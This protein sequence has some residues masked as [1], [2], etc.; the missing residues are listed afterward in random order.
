MLE[1]MCKETGRFQ[2]E[3]EFQEHLNSL[4]IS[5]EDGSQ[6]C[7]VERRGR[8]V[9]GKWIYL[10]YPCAAVCSG[11]TILQVRAATSAQCC[12]NTL[13]PSS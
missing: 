5:L 2:A 10:C 11:E 12:F 1:C 9:S 7:M 4:R 3:Q 6:R 8:D 13:S